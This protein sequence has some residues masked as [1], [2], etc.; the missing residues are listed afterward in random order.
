MQSA[1]KQRLMVVMFIILGAA[2]TV[3]LVLVAFNEGL[4]V[5]F[6][7]TE[8]AEGKAVDNRN[9][10]IGGMVKVGSVVKD[11]LD[12]TRI[13]FVTTDFNKDVPVA[14]NGVLPDLFREGQGVVAEG[15]I[16]ENGVFQAR[17]ILAKHDEN[18]MSAEVKSALDAAEKKKAEAAMAEI[19]KP[20]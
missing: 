12:G 16:D 17:Q 6:T 2:V 4:N 8:I 5:F 18:Y 10:R 20:Q 3:G 9:I 19:G 7:P 15:Y 13:E 1:R 11:G 14:F